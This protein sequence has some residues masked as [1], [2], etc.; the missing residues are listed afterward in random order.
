M[1][2]DVRHKEGNTRR[3]HV[4]FVLGEND[5]Q[6][7]LAYLAGAAKK[8]CHEGSI[9]PPRRY[10]APHKSGSTPDIT[11][12]AEAFGMMMVMVEA[13]EERLERLI[14]DLQEQ[15]LVLEHPA[16]LTRPT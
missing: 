3:V 10:S 9:A 13:R 6:R 16:A 7:L 15:K 8:T 11:E 14:G 5:P 4:G 12:L 1:S 2:V